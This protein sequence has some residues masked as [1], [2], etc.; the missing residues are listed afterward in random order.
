[1]P[2]HKVHT[3]LII[4]K[5]RMHVL[6]RIPY[7]F[8]IAHKSLKSFFNINNLWIDNCDGLPPMENCDMWYGVW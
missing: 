2:V 7:M 3:L 1:M 4:L 6:V 8:V 5:L